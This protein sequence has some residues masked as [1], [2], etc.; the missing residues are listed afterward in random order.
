M[1]SESQSHEDDL[2]E[3]VEEIVRDR[4]REDAIKGLVAEVLDF[5]DIKTD[6]LEGRDIETVR[7]DVIDA[8]KRWTEHDRDLRLHEHIE[9]VRETMELLR[10]EAERRQVSSGVGG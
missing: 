10:V 7:L 4:S 3:L 8:L 6:G 1:A 9:E 2:G 5:V